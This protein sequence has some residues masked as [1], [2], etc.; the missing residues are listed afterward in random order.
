MITITILYVDKLTVSY[1][2]ILKILRFLFLFFIC[3]CMPTPPVIRKRDGSLVPFDAMRIQRA[4]EKAF[5]SSDEMCVSM[6]V[7]MHDIE[8]A[9]ESKQKEL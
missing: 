5:A 9:I 7:L 6:D 2:Y 8:V 1:Y 3:Y 4:I